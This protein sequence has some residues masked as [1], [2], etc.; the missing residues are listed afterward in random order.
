MVD[1]RTVV[2]DLKSYVDKLP[3]FRGSVEE[4]I[5]NIKRMDLK[6]E[7]KKQGSFQW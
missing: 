5:E 7:Y 1:E 2:A 3:N 6:V 4:H